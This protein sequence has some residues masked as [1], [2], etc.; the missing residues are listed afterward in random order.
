MKPIIALCC[1]CLMLGG[2]GGLLKSHEVPALVYTPGM[3]PA[4]P[5][6]SLGSVLVVAHPEAGPGLDTDS[7]TVAL[8]DHRL[9]RLSGAH[10]SAPV[11]ELVQDYLVRYLSARG[12][13]RAVVSDRSAF[14]GTYLLQTGIRAFSAEYSQRGQP[15]RVR[16]WLHGE[17]GRAPDRQLLTSIEAMGDAQASEDRQGAVVA[18]YEAALDAAARKLSDA[19]YAAC[20]AADEAAA[21]PH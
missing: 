7:I 12:G 19:A 15:P 6:K 13:W 10:W 14:T 17:L 5:L 8:P 20:A 21:A 1:A 3:R 18:A 16:V 11:P 2:C 9:D 4:D